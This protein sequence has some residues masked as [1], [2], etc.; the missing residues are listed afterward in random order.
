MEKISTVGKQ[1]KTKQGLFFPVHRLDKWPGQVTVSSQEW[2]Q[3]GTETVKM[4]E[5]YQKLW[6]NGGF[7]IVDKTIRYDQTEKKGML[8]NSLEVSY[9][10]NV[11][12]YEYSIESNKMTDQIYC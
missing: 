12:S 4:M 2:R 5:Q 6:F 3:S 11:N 8:A 10:M 1:W 7:N 9:Y